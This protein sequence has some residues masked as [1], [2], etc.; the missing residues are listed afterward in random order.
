[1]IQGKIEKYWTQASEN[2]SSIIKDELKSYRPDEWRSLIL[3]KAPDKQVLDVLDIGTGPGFFAIILSQ[4]GHRVTG[5]DYAEGMIERARKNAKKLG[6][7]PQFIQMDGH[8]L[9][10]EEGS[11]DLIIS[12]NVTWTLADPVK[13]YRQWLKVLRPGGRLLI[14]DANWHLHYYNK[15]LKKEVERREKECIKIY[16]STYSDN[17]EKKIKLDIEKLPLCKE[18]RPDWDVKILKKLGFSDITS[19]NDITDGLWDDKEKLLYG[20]TPMFMVTAAKKI[21]KFNKNS[22][23]A[24][25]LI[26]S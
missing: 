5:I 21:F 16:G 14:F 1:M 12:R 9:H 26:K 11:F 6:V 10:F 18:L 20:A 2:Y 24:P 23:K 13:M 8:K 25:D 4:A 17:N 7:E 15:D 3:S 19:N 22:A